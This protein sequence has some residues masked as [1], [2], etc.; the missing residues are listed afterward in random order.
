MTEEIENKI[1][2]LEFEIQNH[3]HYLSDGRM[4]NPMKIKR[5]KRDLKNCELKIIEL[6]EK[7][8]NMENTEC[9]MTEPQIEKIRQIISMSATGNDKVLMLI[10]LVEIFAKQECKKSYDKG[11][12]DGCRTAADDISSRI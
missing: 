4:S 2:D 8:K 12:E 1:N 6:K 11:F 9:K 5:R 3:K 7:L 10:D